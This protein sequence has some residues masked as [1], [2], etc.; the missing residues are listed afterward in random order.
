MSPDAPENVSIEKKITYNIKER[1][2]SS[3]QMDMNSIEYSISESSEWKQTIN[4]MFAVFQ[5]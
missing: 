2:D 3:Q 1:W 5:G 4:T